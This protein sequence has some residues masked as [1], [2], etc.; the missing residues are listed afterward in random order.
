M[1]K[2]QMRAAGVLVLQPARHCV[3]H[4]LERMLLLQ[5]RS[6]A[7]TPTVCSVANAVQVGQALL[8]VLLRPARQRAAAR[9]ALQ[10]HRQAEPVCGHGDAHHRRA[11]RALLRHLPLHGVH[12]W[13]AAVLPAHEGLPAASALGQS[14]LQAQT[15][16]WCAW[17]RGLHRAGTAIVAVCPCLRCRRCRAEPGQYRARGFLG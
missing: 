15:A 10:P 3:A 4:T 8:A 12:D 13:C 14:V 2:Q 6:V 11:A 7:L 17:L 1:G 5:H 9:P 16:G